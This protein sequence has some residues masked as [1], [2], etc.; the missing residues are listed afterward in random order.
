MDFRVISLPLG[1]DPDTLIREDALG[2]QQLLA[3][4]QPLLDRLFD[5]I[6]KESDTQSSSGKAA[7]A[8]KLLPLIYS[9][10]DNFIDQDRYFQLLAK[11]LGVS[12]STLQASTGHP[13]SRVSPSRNNTNE[14]RFLTS[15][16]TFTTSESNFT[17]NYCLGLILK[18]PELKALAIQYDLR[19]VFSSENQAL[20]TVYE[21]NDTMEDLRSEIQGTPLEPHLEKL[22]SIKIP[23][24]EPTERTQAL[25]QI[26]RTLHEKRLREIKRL[27][28][29][30]PNRE[31]YP[32][33]E[34]VHSFGQNALNTN[35][36]LRRLFN[37]KDR[38][39]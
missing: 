1:F 35:E 20:F 28:S 8:E 6:A 38:R 7:L 27:E 16:S 14:K 39:S 15:P 17:E 19:A 37:E 5:E 30:I 18:Y 9:S 24:L 12:R 21:E 11:V 10:V 3:E 36:E 32:D 26:L 2:W 22:V 31:I 29:E 34:S 33:Q 23:P 4:S 25:K 13:R